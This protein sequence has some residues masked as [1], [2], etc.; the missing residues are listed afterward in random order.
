MATEVEYKERIRSY[1]RI[2]LW[3]LWR[4][5]QRNQVGNE[6][7]A[8]GKLLEYIILRAFELE[9][10][11]VTYPYSVNLEGE[12]VEQI[13]GAIKIESLYALIECKDYSQ[14]PIN[15][16]PLAKLRNQLLRRHASIFGMFFSMSDYTSPAESLVQFMAPQMVIL[17]TKEDIEYCMKHRCYIKCL[18]QKYKMAIEHCEYNYQYSLRGRI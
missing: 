14:N 3:R 6:F 11:E 17:W 15:I 2:G 16:A 13:D 5:K 4:K 10:A 7:W 9:G 18:R 8:S 12:E 1:G